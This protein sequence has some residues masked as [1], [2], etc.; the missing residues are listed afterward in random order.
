MTVFFSLAPGMRYLLTGLMFL[1]AIGQLALC[2]YQHLCRS[3]WKRRIPDAALFGA[4]LCLCAWLSAASG[5]YYAAPFPWL[6][7]PLAALL[8]CFHFAAGLRWEYR[9]SL[10]TL[11]PASIKQ[12]LDNLESGIL[13]ADGSGRAVLVNYTMGRLAIELCGSYP[14]TLSDLTG[15]LAGRTGT[16]KVTCI[17]DEPGLCRFPDGRVWQFRTVPLH[18]PTLAGFTQTTAREITELYEMNARL[19]QDN[20]A[21][22]ETIRRTQEMAARLTE[23]IPRQEALNLKIRIHNDI[24]SS[25]IAL[26]RLLEDGAQEDP[27]TQLAILNRALIPFGSEAPVRPGTFEAARRQA[28]EMDVT[29]LFEGFLPDDPEIERLIA[30]AARECVTNC[31]RHAGGRMVRVRITRGGGRFAATITNDGRPPDGPVTE[32]GGL[33]ALRRSIENAGGTMSLSSAPRF[34][35]TMTLPE[36]RPEP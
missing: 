24:G 30:A 20:A 2:L 35:L 3:P 7:I 28:A 29:L 25:L 13:F 5:G 23:L 10:E 21:L 14:Q 33:S 16:G 9:R 15:A 22:R 32:G 27:E 18:E 4:L 26:S 36:R 11:S 31:V 17:G 12:A 8:L 19:E 6:I 34:A 1:A